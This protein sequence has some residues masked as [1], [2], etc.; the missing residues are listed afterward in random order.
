MSLTRQETRLLREAISLAAKAREAGDPPF[1]SLVADSS[2]QSLAEEMNTTLSERDIT[3]HPELK[4][5]R[6][7]AQN[8][9]RTEASGL[10][11]YTSCEPCSMCAGAIARSG[12]GRVVFALS[13]DQLGEVKPAGAPSPLSPWTADG[14][15]LRREA[16]EPLIGYY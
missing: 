12:I 10:T 4:I 11:M 8:Y 9:T 7:V 1:G 14:P 5:A 6:W 13:G 16:A 15:H 2:M 3:A